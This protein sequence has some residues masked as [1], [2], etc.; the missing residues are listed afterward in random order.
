MT[1]KIK[2]GSGPRVIVCPYLILNYLDFLS[3][4]VKEPD[5]PAAVKHVD[6]VH[7]PKRRVCEKRRVGFLLA[8]REPLP[9]QVQLKLLS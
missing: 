2:M 9:R 1:G 6:L 5:T 7:W 4:F 3:Y 8:V